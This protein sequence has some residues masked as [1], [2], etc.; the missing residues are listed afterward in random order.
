M[1]SE[2]NGATWLRA[3]GVLLVLAGVLALHALTAG[4]QA[5]PP[6]SDAA[7]VTA[8]EQAPVAAHKHW[9]VG[10]GDRRINNHT[11]AQADQA[12]YKDLT[13]VGP[14][15]PEDECP[16]CGQHPAPTHPGS[17]LLDMCAAALLAGA[18]AVVLG[19]LAR[20]RQLLPTPRAPARTRVMAEQVLSALRA[21][22]P[23]ALGV[24]RT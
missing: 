12:A 6:T 10:S 9:P 14:A 13:P 4:H 5:A 3:G 11:A 21:P 15:G 2:R 16:G 19:L 24:L 1:D 22:C 23:W 8:P 18:F 20:A 7:R 17:H